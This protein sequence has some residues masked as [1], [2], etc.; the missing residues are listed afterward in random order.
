[1]LEKKYIGVLDVDY[2]YL[3]YP[4][5]FFIIESAH[6]EVVSGKSL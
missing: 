4:T 5:I 6:V 2:V 3:Y 1:M